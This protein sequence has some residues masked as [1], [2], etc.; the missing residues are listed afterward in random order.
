MGDM[1]RDATKFRG[2]LSLWNVSLVTDMGSMFSSTDFFNSN[3]SAWNTKKN[4]DFSYMFYNAIAFNQD[5]SGWPTEAATTY[6]T[7]FNGATEFLAKYSCVNAT[8]PTPTDL[9]LCV[10]L[11][12]SKQIGSPRAH[13]LLRHLLRS[14][15]RRPPHLRRQRL[16][17]QRVGTDFWSRVKSV[18]T[19]VISMVTITSD[20]LR[21]ARLN[22]VLFALESV[23]MKKESREHARA[24]TL[25]VLGRVLTICVPKF[26]IALSRPLSRF[27]G[28]LCGRLNGRPVR[29]L[30]E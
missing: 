27:R 22:P 30:Y 2:D 12:Q 8:N 6:S 18:M 29:Q 23:E 11:H 26:E 28:Q 4:R 19:G 25:W 21:L 9:S 10:V 24:P 1:F 16:L 20:V 14:H 15:L 17:H 5:V 7:M 3:I 13:R